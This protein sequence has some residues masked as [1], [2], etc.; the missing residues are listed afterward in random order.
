M[1]RSRKRK[2]KK[3][4]KPGKIVKKERGFHKNKSQSA[5]KTVFSRQL[6]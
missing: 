2:E 5:I 1:N 4:Q 6:Q 3:K